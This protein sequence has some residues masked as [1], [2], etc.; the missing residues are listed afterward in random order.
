[1]GLAV[2]SHRSEQSDSV[3]GIGYVEI[4]AGH[5]RKISGVFVA[6]KQEMTSIIK[7]GCRPT[8]IMVQNKVRVLIRFRLCLFDGL[9]RKI[10]QVAELGNNARWIL[11]RIRTFHDLL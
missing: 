8:R 6:L 10:V 5:V 11:K 4:D 3:R 9:W 2:R 1:M 7:T